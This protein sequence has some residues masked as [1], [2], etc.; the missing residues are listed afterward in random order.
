M[1][2][3]GAILASASAAGEFGTRG[4][5]CRWRVVLDAPGPELS[6]VAAL[7]DRNIWAVGND[8]ERGAMLHWDGHRWRRTPFPFLAFDIDAVSA[9]DVWAVGSSA[10]GG[11]ET[12]PRAAHWAGKGWNVVPAPGGSRTYLRGVAAI[13]RW[14]VWAVGAKKRG[15]LLEHWNGS[16]WTRV[17][18]GP[19]D[20]LLHAIDAL[21]PDDVWAVGTQ[22]MRTLGEGSEDSLV[23]RLRGGLWQSLPAP[24]LDRLDD[25]LLAVSAESSTDVW[26]VGSYDEP[27]RAP[28]AMRW[29]GQAWSVEPT[30]ELPRRWTSLSAVAAIGPGDVWAAGS[31]GIGNGERTLL[32]H[33]DGVRWTR[34]PARLGSLSDLA[35]LS[36]RDIWAVG[37]LVSAQGKSRTLVEHYACD[38]S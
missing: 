19:R 15:P 12:R 3:L 33:W 20:G 26:A 31:H 2:V 18:G 14:N 37:G 34:M 25:R 8:G 28:L 29:D 38:A 7:T 27:D 10:A 5:P 13:S 11:V 16:T 21:S 23:E 30:S 9:N 32:A 1:G 22:E 4:T 17:P 35:V 24:E 6:G 36:P